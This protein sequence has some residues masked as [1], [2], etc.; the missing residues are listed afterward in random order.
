MEVDPKKFIK[1]KMALN[2]AI[3]VLRV[4][5]MA[6]SLRVCSGLT[7]LKCLLLRINLN[8]TM[9][10]VEVEQGAETFIPDDLSQSS[11]PYSMRYYD[12]ILAMIQE[13]FS[14]EIRNLFVMR[15]LVAFDVH[16]QTDFLT[17]FLRGI[18]IDPEREI[19]S[20][21]SRLTFQP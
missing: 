20:G 17:N 11:L 18:G 2:K 12:A 10:I 5:R 1:M 7:Y 14:D 21:E 3:K 16:R 19:E 15:S 4:L 13:R 6:L 9:F 8:R